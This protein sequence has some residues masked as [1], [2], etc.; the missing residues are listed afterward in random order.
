LLLVDDEEGIRESLSEFLVLQGYELSVASG[1]A[2]A[3][4]LAQARPPRVVVS[5]MN[6]SQGSGLSLL[7]KLKQAPPGGVEPFCILITG[8]GTLDTA[9][10]AL[11]SGID[12][13][14]TKPFSLQELS[15]SLEKARRRQAPAR[16]ERNL[17]ADLRRL[18]HELAA[19]LSHMA[20]Y[21]DMME[22]G[23]FGPVGMV[24]AGKLS[25]LQLGLRRALL[26]LTALRL[27]GGEAFARPRLERLQAEGLFRLVLNEF[28]LDFERRG[29]SVV[30]CVP[31]SLPMVLVDRHG[32]YL[33]F[34]TVLASVLLNA[35][36]GQTLRLQWEATRQDLVLELQG[37]AVQGNPEDNLWLDLPRLDDHWLEQAG[38]GQDRSSP[39][40]IRLRFLNLRPEGD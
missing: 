35:R 29:V 39:E 4:D 36:P 11:R 6:L 8:Y 2:E 27:G 1:E 3:W 34:E 19:P 7:R 10:E 38:L 20:T 24:Q 17:Q 25:S 23:L 9:V 32:A 18:D 22:Q 33:A 28:H 12:D 16:P 14:L 31:Q 21:L 30:T 26:G 5:D 37:D 15:G 13:L 40:R